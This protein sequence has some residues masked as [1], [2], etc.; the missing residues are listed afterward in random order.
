MGSCQLTSG[1]VVCRSVDGRL[2]GPALGWG[3]ARRQLV[4]PQGAEALALT[5]R[6]TMKPRGTWPRLSPRFYRCAEPSL[7]VQPLGTGRPSRFRRLVW[8]VL[9]RE[10]AVLLQMQRVSA[11]YR[12]A[13]RARGHRR[14]QPPRLRRGADGRVRAHQR[15]LLAAGRH[16]VPGAGH[17][18]T[19][20]DERQRQRVCVAGLAHASLGYQAPWSRLTSAA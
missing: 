19:A 16:L 8:A 18:H 15:G 11:R 2:R 10:P 13:I 17:R 4:P 20:R 7:T 6:R 12:V 3:P 1:E 9:F 5:G 14:S